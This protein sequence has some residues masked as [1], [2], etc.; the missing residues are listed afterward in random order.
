MEIDLNTSM[1]SEKPTWV[2]AKA[3]FWMCRASK[4]EEESDDDYILEPFLEDQFEPLEWSH[5][6]ATL[7]VCI[8]KVVPTQFL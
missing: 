6:L 3:Q 2:K 8:N 4:N 1:D 7:D 5:V